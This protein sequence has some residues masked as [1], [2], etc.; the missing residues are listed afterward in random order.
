MPDGR[1]D[2]KVNGWVGGQND[3]RI[4]AWK[5]GKEREKKAEIKQVLI[6]RDF[7]LH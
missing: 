6:I 7:T 2:G 3:E 4:E 5:D 1:M